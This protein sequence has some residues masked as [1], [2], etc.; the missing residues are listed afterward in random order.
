MTS[1]ASTSSTEADAC[2]TGQPG[3]VKSSSARAPRAGPQ[4]AADVAEPWSH[5]LT[6]PPSTSRASTTGCTACVAQSVNSRC[7]AQR[8]AEVWAADSGLLPKPPSTCNKA[9]L[10]APSPMTPFPRLLQDVPS[11]QN[12]CELRFTRE[13]SLVRNQPR[14]SRRSPAASAGAVTSLPL[15]GPRPPL[16]GTL[17]RR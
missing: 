17:D 16:R 11:L 1:S 5:C 15:E 13:R 3:T 12:L 10:Y 6:V 8:Q 2:P 4:S 7:R 9:P 14:P